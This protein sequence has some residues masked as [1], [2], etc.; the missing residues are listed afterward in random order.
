[1]KVPYIALLYVH[2]FVEG[3][4]QRLSAIE[5]GVIDKTFSSRQKGDKP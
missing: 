1:M 4:G 2:V 5:A 3:E